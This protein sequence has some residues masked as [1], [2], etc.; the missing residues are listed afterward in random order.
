MGQLVE[1]R[2]YHYK[3][4]GWE[5]FQI[6]VTEAMNILRDHFDVVGFWFDVGIPP[7][8]TGSAPMDLPYGSANFTWLLRW[9][10]MEQ[11]EKGWN[12]LSENQAMVDHWAKHP[13]PSGLLH[14]S[15][16]FL[17]EA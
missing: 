3:L 14:H 1:F 8:I 10:D 13:D 15:A 16:R 4:D 12:A 6:W 9:D 17:E 11:C 2:D 7:K 5:E